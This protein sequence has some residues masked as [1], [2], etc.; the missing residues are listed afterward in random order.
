[1]IRRINLVFLCAVVLGL[2]CSCGASG[3]NSSATANSG[4]PSTAPANSPASS[5][6]N[7]SAPATAR[8]ADITTTVDALVKEYNAGPK[9]LE[10]YNGKVLQVSGKF[11]HSAGTETAPEVKFDT[12]GPYV[13]VSCILNASAIQVAA[14]LQKGQ[15]ITMIGTW[16]PMSIIGPRLKDCQMAP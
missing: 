9:S 4:K 15:E 10:K 12:G 6:A 13:S 7:S 8:K 11:D 16:D 1:M 14:K 2:L 3:S 5:S